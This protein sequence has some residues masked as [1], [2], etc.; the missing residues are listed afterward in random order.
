MGTPIFVLFCFYQQH[1]QVSNSL[2]TKCHK[3]R[4][5]EQFRTKC[6][7]KNS[8]NI[9]STLCLFDKNVTRMLQQEGILSVLK[10]LFFVWNFVTSGYYYWKS[11][12]LV[13]SI[14]SHI[15]L[16]MSWCHTCEKS[17]R[18]VQWF[19]SSVLLCISYEIE[20]VRVIQLMFL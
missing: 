18:S 14:N 2:F 10:Y 13:V 19:T 20:C 7:C 9:A 6:W 3:M 1:D 15:L 17:S 12:K 5:C 4:N 11:T 8:S 16:C